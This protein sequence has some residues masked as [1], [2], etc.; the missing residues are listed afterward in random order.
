MEYPDIFGRSMLTD[1][2]CLF[3]GEFTYGT[4]LCTIKAAILLMYYR[5]FPTRFMK[6]GG[7]VLGAITF[8]WWV[9][10][11]FVSIFQCVPVHKT[12]HPFMEGGHCLDKN[13]FF[14]GNSIPNIITDALILCLPVYEV[15]KLQVRRSQKFAIIGIF[16]LGGM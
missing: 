4:V 14:L 7:Y 11:V 2:Q 15:S 13:Q 1:L 6:F 12:W 16:L 8:A 5:V 9:A 3:I 10:V